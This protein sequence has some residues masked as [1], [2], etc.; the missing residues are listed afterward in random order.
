MLGFLVRILVTVGK[1]VA[2]SSNIGCLFVFIADEPVC[3]KS[4]IE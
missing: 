3:P 2:N 1:F 4:L